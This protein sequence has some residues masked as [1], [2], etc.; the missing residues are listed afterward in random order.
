LTFKSRESH[1][2]QAD[3]DL[4]EI[5]RDYGLGVDWLFVQTGNS[6]RNES[7]IAVRAAGASPRV[8]EPMGYEEADPWSAP[9]DL[10]TMYAGR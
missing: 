5:A 4:Q 1:E 10:R 7:G 2:N 6:G 3:A 9:T 8:R